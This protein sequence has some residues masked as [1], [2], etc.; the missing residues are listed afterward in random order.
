MIA[1]ADCQE[2]LE[3]AD[4]RKP[5]LSPAAEQHL[6]VLVRSLRLSSELEDD[7]NYKKMYLTLFNAVTGAIQHLEWHNYGRAKEML[8]Q[9]QRD[10]EEIYINE[11]A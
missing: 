2:V 5:V 10:A 11:E 1:M 4:E 7:V 8:V 3:N 9:A 6:D